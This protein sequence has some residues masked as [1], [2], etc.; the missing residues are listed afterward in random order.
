MKEINN[1]MSISDWSYQGDSDHFRMAYDQRLGLQ[2]FFLF[3]TSDNT[4]NEVE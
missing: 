2:L 3:V 4:S 1:D